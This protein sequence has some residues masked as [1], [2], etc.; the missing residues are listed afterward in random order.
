MSD[1]SQVC[2]RD[3]PTWSGC[4]MFFALEPGVG[5]ALNSL[6]RVSLWFYS[7]V[8]RTATKKILRRRSASHPA[9]LDSFNLFYISSWLPYTW[10]MLKWFSH[11]LACF[12]QNAEQGVGRGEWGRGIPWCP[13]CCG[14]THSP[15]IAMLHSHWLPH[16]SHSI[17]IYP[18]LSLSD[19]L[20]AA[21]FEVDQIMRDQAAG[22]VRIFWIMCSS[23]MLSQYR[24]HKPIQECL[25][26]RF[27]MMFV[28]AK[29]FKV[30]V[31]ERVECA[32]LLH[33]C[34]LVRSGVI[35]PYVATVGRFKHWSSPCLDWP[36]SE[37]R[38]VETC[39]SS[40]LWGFLV[41]TA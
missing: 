14:Q 24:L 36:G 25:G 28:L 5:F 19:R 2:G 13:L 7:P 38:F 39:W 16:L 27:L 12:H 20:N 1:E 22:H 11:I 8:E 10:N 17:S 26:C 32:W 40:L 6:V 18:I 35:T 34:Y 31:L 29:W 21:C 30:M 15:R 37:A 41:Q 4:S 33:R 3:R 9:V 23:Y